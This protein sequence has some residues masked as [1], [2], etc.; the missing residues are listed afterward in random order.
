MGQQATRSTR[1]VFAGTVPASLVDFPGHVATTL[2]TQ[3]CN[4]R[5]GYCHNPMLVE[6]P[7]PERPLSADDAIALLERRRRLV[8]HVCLTGGEPTLHPGLIAFLAAL[9]E[10]GF[11][12]KLDTNGGRPDVIAEVLRQGIC[13]Y[14]AMDLKTA[15]HRYQE[16][17]AKDPAPFRQTAEMIRSEA[18]NYEF[19]T[20]V[21]P[22]LV[23]EADVFTIA[24]SIR[25]ARR[26]T[27]QQFSARGRMLAPAWSGIQPHPA[28]RLRAWAEAMEGW[29]QE[30]VQ[31]RSA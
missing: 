1:I 12:V 26:Y 8:R 17:G 20:T 13:D 18:P 22:G 16:I 4:L 24:E 19:R 25:G 27:L 23:E 14:I 29:F 10:R 6:G 21:A 5:C 30:P 15:W 11:G 3:G 28:D 2:F 9:K 31:V 7:P